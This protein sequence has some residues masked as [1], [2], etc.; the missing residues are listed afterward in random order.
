MTFEGPR[1][2]TFMAPSF[3]KKKKIIFEDHTGINIS[4]IQAGF[5]VMYSLKCVFSSD[6]RA[7]KPF[8]QALRNGRKKGQ[9]TSALC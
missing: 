4:I 9:L 3:I 5:T 2:L 8:S 1:P 7:I 6:L